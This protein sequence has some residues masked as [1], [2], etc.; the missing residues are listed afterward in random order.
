MAK[1]I[2]LSFDLTRDRFVARDFLKE[3]SEQKYEVGVVG[4]S[5]RLPILETQRDLVLAE[6]IGKANLM[7]MLISPLSG[8]SKSQAQEFSAAGQAGVPVIG[9]YVNGADLYSNLPGNLSRNQVYGWD[10]GT[11]RRRLK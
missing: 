7:V 6:G 2:Y 8:A 5:K 11:L 10:W 9:V 1:N 3:L 4:A